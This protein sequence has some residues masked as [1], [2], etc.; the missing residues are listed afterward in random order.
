VIVAFDF[1][2]VPTLTF[3]L[4]LW[5]GERGQRCGY[6]MARWRRPDLKWGLF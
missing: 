2:T 1:F 4:P 6:A 5:Q 3:R